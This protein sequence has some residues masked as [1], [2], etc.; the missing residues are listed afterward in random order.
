MTFSF[1]CIFW[2]RLRLHQSL[3]VLVCSKQY[4]IK[5]K[6]NEQLL[7]TNIRL[8]EVLRIKV[9]P[10]PQFFFFFFFFWGGV[11]YTV[12]NC[13]G[14]TVQDISISWPPG[15]NF[16]PRDCGKQTKS[17]QNNGQRFFFFGWRVNIIKSQNSKKMEF[18]TFLRFV[19][20]HL[21]T[22][23]KRLLVN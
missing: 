17:K 21:P 10:P 5:V 3:V 9:H 23:K 11:N 7:R 20:F 14:F 22:K 18:W 8:T 12:F 15:V 4:K 16:C 1:P 2:L 13:T 19:Y 6:C